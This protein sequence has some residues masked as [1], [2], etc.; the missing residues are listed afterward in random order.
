MDFSSIFFIWIFLPL[1]LLLYYLSRAVF[2]SDRRR[3]SNIVLLALSVV[4]YSFGGFLSLLTF[5]LMILLN[6]AAGIAIEKYSGSKSIFAV[7]VSLNVLI[8][9]LFK[10]FF[11]GSMLAPLALSFVV[12]QSIAYLADV[13]KK[14]SIAEHNFLTFALFE[15]LFAQVVQGPIMRYNSLA[16]QIKER[17]ETADGFASGIRRF[18]I[19]LAK[20]VLIANT[21]AAAAEPIWSSNYQSIQCSAAWLGIVF[22]TF[23]I[24]YDFSGYTD[25]AIGI[26][27]MFGFEICENF[28]HPYIS[29]SIQEFW[30]RW[31][32]SLSQWFRDYIYIPLGGSRKGKVRTLFNLFIV[33][34]LTGIWHGSTLNFVCWGLYFALLSII[35]RLFLGN[36]LKK[37][38]VKLLNWAYSFFAVMLGWVM[39]RAPSMHEALQYYKAMFIPNTSSY[40]PVALSY[41]DAQT[42]IAL[43]SAVLF[44][45][46]INKLFSRSIAKIRNT[47]AA[48]I[49][50][51]AF[52]IVLLIISTIMVVSGSFSPSIYG[53]F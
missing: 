20:K 35:E 26:G 30:R 38:P 48:M 50:D 7:S 41:L 37:N 17:R 13:Y 23:Q 25:M 40:A 3:A 28:N 39:F 44:C 49:I 11:K 33:F 52:S 12:F 42:L 6:Y 51:S 47:N 27:R 34:L 29:L 19:G 2:K 8:L 10:Y 21:I 32:I 9:V 4:F 1:A 45:G 15:S 5:V 16:P 31:H 53:A 14:E 46:I 43:I 36:L 24:Y 22:Y 18:S